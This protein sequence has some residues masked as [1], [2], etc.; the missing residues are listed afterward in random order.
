MT[1]SEFYRAVFPNCDVCEDIK[2]NDYELNI[3]QK[4]IE[5]ISEYVSSIDDPQKR[6]HYF[7]DIIAKPNMENGKLFELLVYA[8]LK[9]KYIDFQ[10][11]ILIK[12]YDCLKK[13]DYYADGIFSEIV[14][15]IK[16]FGIGYPLYGRFRERLQR[17]TDCYCITVGGQKNLSA[18]MIETELMSKIP[19]WK[20]RLFSK[21]SKSGNDYI[22]N[23]AD[24]GIEIRAHYVK[25]SGGMFTSISEINIT[26]WAKENELYF[27]RHAS[28]FCIN[29]PYMIICPFLPHD[30]PLLSDGENVYYAFRY[31]CRRMF[32]NLTK[33]DTMFLRHID[34]H[35][36]NQ[37]T[38]QMAAKKL[39]AM[40]FLDISEEWDYQN[41]RCWIYKNPNADF[42]IPNY[43]MHSAFKLLGVYSVDFEYDNY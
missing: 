41:C 32:M 42:P 38:I 39:S 18:K 35:A 40:M 29:K 31:L 13:N 36:K 12:S 17:E 34:G 33:K 8:W 4:Y 22:V 5:R 37:I 7:K 3:G 9:K 24:I 20:E 2:K 43:I 1:A 14:F 11:Q 19:Y 23:D 15:D 6:I 30:L 16:K 27:F 25:R 28:Q 10:E 21:E 26:K